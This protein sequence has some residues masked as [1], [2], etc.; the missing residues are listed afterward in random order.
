MKT[1]NLIIRVSDLEKQQIKDAADKLQ[2]S[3]S[4]Y[5]LYLFRKEPKTYFVQ[6]STKK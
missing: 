1:T 5:M 2:M 6:E 4:E 3:M